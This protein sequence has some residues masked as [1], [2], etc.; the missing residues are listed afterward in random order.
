MAGMVKESFTRGMRG[1][2]L[3][4][5]PSQAKL[6]P[7]R[8]HLEQGHLLAILFKACSP[9]GTCSPAPLVNTTPVPASLIL[10]PSSQVGSEQQPW[11]SAGDEGRVLPCRMGGKAHTEPLL[12]RGEEDR[13]YLGPSWCSWLGSGNPA[14]ALPLL[15]PPRDCR[16]LLRKQQA[17]SLRRQECYFLGAKT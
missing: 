13:P 3:C 9:L 4:S 14:S 11:D 6:S 17:R 8:A 1:W 12:S 2:I 5:L 15:A 10:D 7:F 16:Q